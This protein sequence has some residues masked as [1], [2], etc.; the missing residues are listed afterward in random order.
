MQVEEV[1]RVVHT[2]WNLLRSCATFRVQIQNCT[3]DFKDTSVF[4]RKTKYDVSFKE[5]IN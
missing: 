3:W 2:F 4:C 1:A 5:N